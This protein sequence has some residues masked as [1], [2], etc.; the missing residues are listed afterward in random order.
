MIRW[1]PA[2]IAAALALAAAPA[3]ARQAPADTVSLRDRGCCL[4]EVREGAVV[5]ELKIHGNEALEDATIENAIH[6]TA[7]GP[8]PWSDERRLDKQEFL[9]DLVR[10]H[11][12][13]QR[14]GYFGARL[15]SWE[16]EPEPDG[17]VRVS[18]TMTEGE[19]T[20][21]DSLRIEG[22]A[23]VADLPGADELREQLPLRE[24]EVFNESDLAASRDTLEAVLKN[25]GHAFGQVLMEYRIRKEERRASVTYRLDPGD[26]YFIGEVRYEG[27]SEENR[28]LV[29]RQLKFE[30]GERYDR[31]E[32]LE[33]QRSL[34]RLALF[35]RVEIEPQLSE[36]EGDSVDVL[37][38]VSPAPTH[39][40]RVGVG[41]G[42]QDLFRA[43]A[44]WLN[45]NVF[46]Q[47]RQ[48]EVRGD[49]SRLE[50]EGAV[51]Y[52]QPVLF[53][54]EGS[55]TASAFLRF[56]TEPNY[57]VERTGATARVGYRASR[58][59]TASAGL[60]AERDDF[61]DFDEGVLIPQLGRDFINPSRLVFVDAGIAYDNTDSLFRP[62][63]GYRADLGYQAGLPVAGTDYAYQK[64]TLEVTH[65][66]EV[67]EG[68]VVA[69]KALPGAIFLYSGDPEEGGEGRV[70]LFQRL[71]AGGASSVRGFE[72]RQLGPKDDPR[73]FGQERDPEPIG[74][75]GLFETSVELRFPLRGNFR[76]AAFVDAG[77]VWREVADISL[78]DLKYTPGAGVRYITPVG[79]I[80]LDVAR[81]ISDEEEFL[82]RWVFHISIGNAF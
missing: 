14:H 41:Y 51:T 54:P 67:T 17:G 63:R 39:V 40:V 78:G 21:V 52:R 34:Y 68:W 12:L 6:T 66:V 20:L 48:L 80:R 53:L 55:F 37:V 77:N 36:V 1:A 61:S 23:E 9:K 22:V 27:V 3:A 19:P 11:V 24:G 30:T 26:V 58:T 49:Y 45:R 44:S 32:I 33:S 65:Y 35:R 79:P 31:E 42:T 76:G 10:L 47:N 62:S 60:T 2:W 82:P 57:T 50:R 18:F 74:G 43:S 16:L 71:F 29:R 5:E 70:P 81:R 13:Y 4:E 7:T 8:W 38:S 25:R 46:G 56:E 59:I 28:E 75:R 73:R 64:V 15:V 69:M 72:R